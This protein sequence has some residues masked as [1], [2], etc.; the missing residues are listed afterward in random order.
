MTIAIFGLKFFFEHALHKEW[1]TFNIVRPAPERKLPV[2]LSP[3]EVRRFS[4]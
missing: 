3:T 2:I 1:T 4:R